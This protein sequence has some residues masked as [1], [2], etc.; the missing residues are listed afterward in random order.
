MN[1]VINP[2]IKKYNGKWFIPQSEIELPGIL[3]IDETT[4]NQ[5][6]KIY[7][8]IDFKGDSL[9]LENFE[10]RDFPTICGNYGNDNK[11]TLNDC[12]FNSATPIG[13]DIYEIIYK[14][15]FSFLGGILI[16][17]TETK[18]IQLT[19]TFPYFSSWFDTNQLY[20]GSH[21]S[22]EDIKDDFI[23]RMRPALSKDKLFDEINI[24]DDFSIIIERKYQLEAWAFNKDV[25]AEIKHFVHFRCQVS[26]SFNE[27]K[28]LAY[29]FMELIKLSTGKLMQVNFLSVTINKDELYDYS[30][31]LINNN[32]DVY[33][34]ITHFNNQLKRNLIE[35]D[36]IHQNYMLFYGGT[37]RTD[38]LKQ[39]IVKWFE[40]YDKFS[41][42]YNNFLDTFE[43][44]QNTDA[45]LSQV[46]F[47]NRFLNL[48]QALESYHAF[49]FPEMRDE[50]KAEI[51]DKARE[52]LKEIT[53]RN[54]A[55]WLIKRIYPRHISLSQR[56]R[57]LLCNELNMI[58]EEI[59]INRQKKNDYIE[60]IRIIRNKLSH[61]EKV[62]FNSEEV[63]DYYYK[64]LIILLSCILTNLGFSQIEIKNAL[65]QT[66]KYEQMISYI[67]YQMTVK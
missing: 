48:V 22:N 55:K 9:A 67:K 40:T 44:F 49:S 36:Y 27:F 25:K 58:T 37:S 61:G 28:K 62:D 8:K 4:F 17:D 46:M 43:W 1:T 45:N 30:K 51:R 33:I 3:T 57:D 21:S 56:L 47:N 34:A 13:D 12:A 52:L 41:P 29:R 7:S 18:I 6:L 2:N 24:N 35:S 14:P 26:K 50:G 16:N 31:Y 39:T 19:C 64:T 32:G 59:F 10:P 63:S 38:K 60:E 54:D 65:F 20:F 11:I 15:T 66:L 42:V 23:E 5:I 53:N